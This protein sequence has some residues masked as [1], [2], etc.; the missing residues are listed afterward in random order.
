[1]YSPLICS[2]IYKFLLE[3]NCI[4]SKIQKIFWSDISGVIEHTELLS[5]II[6]HARKKQRQAIITLL[7]LQNAFGEVDHRLLLKVLDYHH[8]PVELKSLIKDYYHSY[9]LS[10]GTGN[11]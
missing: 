1:M 5:Y 8:V 10:I 7:D 4:E 3:N 2:R 6:N 11:Y 9:A